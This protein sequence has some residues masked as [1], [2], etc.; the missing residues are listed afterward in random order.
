MICVGD[1]RKTCLSNTSVKFDS[2]II[3]CFGPVLELEVSS[4][5]IS[6]YRFGL[7]HWGLW[8]VHQYCMGSVARYVSLASISIEM[9]T[10]IKGFVKTELGD[11]LF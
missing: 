5:S 8:K 11:S 2:E 7:W 4:A 1:V 10:C 3:H 6:I 9:S